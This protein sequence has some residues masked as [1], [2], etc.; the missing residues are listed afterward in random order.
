M[1]AQIRVL[2]IEDMPDDAALLLRE[3]RRGGYE[4]ISRRVD[5]PA[6][7]R[8]ALE[9][10]WEVILCDF[11]LPGMDA[12]AALRMVQ[13]SGRDIPFIIVSGSVG[14]ETAVAA[15]RAGAHDYLMKNNTTRL[16]EVVRREL[17][18]AAIREER[19]RAD[20]SVRLSEERFRTLV[21]AIDDIVFTVDLQHRIT[22]LY[23]GGLERGQV[24]LDQFVGKTIQEVLGPEAGERHAQAARRALD[25][26][27]GSYEFFRDG[28]EGPRWYATS[29]SPM[30][31]LK[32]ELGGLV[33]ISRDV[34]EQK[35]MLAKLREQDRMA[36]LGMLSAGVAH[37]INNPMA[38]VIGNVGYAAKQVD[39]LLQSESPVG[40][41]LQERLADVRASLEEIQD[42]TERVRLIVRDLKAFTRTEEERRGPVEL[43][44]VMQAS[45]AM[46]VAEVTHRATV[47][48]QFQPCP[49]VFGNH[50]RL[51]QVFLN[52]II[53]AAQAM[54]RRPLEQNQITLRVCERAGVAVAE[55]CDN[56]EGISPEVLPRIFDPLFT[57]KPV[58]VGTGLG[59]AICK[60]LVVELGGELSVESRRGV[61][62]TFRV[63]LPVHAGSVTAREP[64][65]PLSLRRGRVLVVDDEAMLRASIQRALKADHE[66]VGTGAAAEALELLVGGQRFD[67]ILSDLSMPGMSGIDLHARLCDALP[68]QAER[69]IFMTGGIVTREANDFVK[70]IAN[71]VLD[72]PFDFDQLKLEIG[73]LVERS[74]GT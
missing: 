3:L 18:E 69:M 1:G 32:G 74:A 58:G 59:L 6:A 54:P 27:G 10:P 49:P 72:K 19:A 45:L 4:P 68:E 24:R 67:A 12:L 56:G 11:N 47:V 38:Y 2:T 41:Q 46:A 71:P 29:L 70:R 14:E 21:T 63:T 44:S 57:T 65:K 64:V 17:R 35:K 7:L 48:K 20:R 9:E 60:D 62:S 28:R 39:A 51:G 25:G 23:G 61:G 52:L 8:A 42:G 5:T 53:N 33:G 22:G 13:E 31:G 30:R 26:E 15:M 50:S 55:V 37:E 36:T 16:V 40:P 43:A 34:T 73:R 66:V